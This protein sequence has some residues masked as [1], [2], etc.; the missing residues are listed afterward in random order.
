[1]TGASAG[2]ILLIVLDTPIR[3][4][5]SERRA[6]TRLEILDAAWVL[7]R[8]NGLAELTLRDVAERVETLWRME[9]GRLVAPES[10]VVA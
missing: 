10:V 6:A 5:Q 4:R 8:D 9:H 2:S 7:A 1:M 3:D